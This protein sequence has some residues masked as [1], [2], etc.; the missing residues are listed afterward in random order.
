VAAQSAEK[1]ALVTLTL[2]EGAAPGEAAR[3]FFGADEV[4]GTPTSGTINGLSAVGGAFTAQTQQGTFQGEIQFVAHGGLVFQLMGYAS[5]ER[6][7]ARRDAARAAIRSVRRLTDQQILAV[8]PWRMDIV[9]VDRTLT[10]AEFAQ[11]YPGP[12]TA[13]EIALINQMDAGG[14]FM[15]RNL[16]KRVVGT[17]FQR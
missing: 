9:R 5:S 1:D 15:S 8:Q 3:T 17:P 16:V 4:S 12:V 11:R 10:P 7:P 6:W 14:R 2:A 13:G